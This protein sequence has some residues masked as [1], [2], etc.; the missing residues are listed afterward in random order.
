MQTV[1]ELVLH[2]RKVG[3][4]AA[5]GHPELAPLLKEAMDR[6][7][8]EPMSGTHLFSITLNG[9]AAARSMKGVHVP[10]LW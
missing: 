5:V 10:F 6:G 9:R 7:W 4:S 1:E 2:M 8:V 3:V